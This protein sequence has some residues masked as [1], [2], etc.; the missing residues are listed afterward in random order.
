MGQDMVCE[1]GVRRVVR[2]S[3]G[4]P[5]ELHDAGAVA[6]E[7]DARIQ[8]LAVRNTLATGLKNPQHKGA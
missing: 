1:A 3:E 5:P 2:M 4:Q 6:A 7:I 8:A